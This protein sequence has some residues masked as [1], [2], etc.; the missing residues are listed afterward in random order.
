MLLML[1][2]DFKFIVID[3]SFVVMFVDC[4]IRALDLSG[5]SHH[6][7]I[8]AALLESLLSCITVIEIATFLVVC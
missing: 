2:L 6:F 3:V 4:E 5:T 8:T 1:V 7:T